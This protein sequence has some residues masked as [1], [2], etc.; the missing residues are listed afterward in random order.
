MK[1]RMTLSFALALN[2]LLSLVSFS[3]PANA[4]QPQR[5]RF[6]TGVVNPGLGQTLRVTVATGDVN[7]DD[8]RARIGWM[9]YGAASCSGMPA[10]CRHTIESQGVTAA[11][12]LSRTD[13]ISFDVTGDGNGVNIVVESNSRNAKVLGIVFDTSTQRIVAIIHPSGDF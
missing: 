3:S 7:G 9:R 1:N 10:V 12:T 4:Q 6:A 8:I 13:A 11:T 5:F 2:L